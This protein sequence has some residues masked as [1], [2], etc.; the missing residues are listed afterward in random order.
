M[1][2]CALIYVKD[3]ETPFYSHGEPRE[4]VVVQEILNSGEWILPLRN[5]VELPSKPPLF[6]WLGAI[7]SSI[8]NRVDEFTVRFPSALTASL[9]VLLTFLTGYRFWGL[10][11]GLFSALILGTGFEW[12]RAATTARV[13]MTLTF[14]MLSALIVFSHAYEYGP[15]RRRHTYMFFSACALAV[16]TKGPVGIVLPILIVAV[17]LLLKRD[18]AFC[19]K[20]HLWEGGLLLLMLAGCWYALALWKGGDPFFGKQFLREN[21]LRFLGEDGTPHQQPFYYLIPYPFLSM[22]PWSLFFPSLAIFLY[23]QRVRLAEKKLLFP[24]VWAATVLVFFTL[25]SGKRSVYILPLY[26][27]LGLL[28]GA[29][30]QS[31]VE[32]KIASSRLDEK[33]LRLS[34]SLCMF[35]F[36]F[37]MAIIVLR[38]SGSAY[39]GHLRPFLASDPTNLLFTGEARALLATLVVWL[40]VLGATALFLLIALKRSLWNRVFAALAV[41]TT[42][43]LL[44][45]AGIFYPLRAHERSFKPFMERVRQEVGGQSP[46]LFYRA[47]DYGAL[48]YAG[49]RVPPASQDIPVSQSPVFMLTWEEEWTRLSAFKADK[50]KMIAISDGADPHGLRR[51]ALIRIPGSFP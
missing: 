26:P 23:R 6:H 4:A 16:L 10:K 46:L 33:T 48:F 39:L 21:L 50:I 25:S 42:V 40:A 41:F 35:L 13:D 45:I 30:W 51:L 19:K 34:G 47:F 22:L 9:G 43:N 44:I 38:L 18:L 12:W 17:F 11:A 31:L 29:W 27:A 24:L 1:L 7:G 20:M 2:F 8:F 28:L 3:L 15:W 5:G 14:F 49:G 37:F 32:S 36:F